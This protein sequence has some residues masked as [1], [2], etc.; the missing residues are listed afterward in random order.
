MYLEIPTIEATEMRRSAQLG[1]KETNSENEAQRVFRAKKS[2]SDDRTSNI[3]T[4]DN[5]TMVEALKYLN[6]CQLAKKSLVSKRFRD[7]IQ[8]HRH[9]LA[10]LYVDTI[11]MSPAVNQ[12]QCFIFDKYFDFYSE[13]YNEWVILN[14]YSKQA[15]L[16]DQ[17]ANTQ[18]SQNI[19]NGYQLYA[20]AHYK[21]PSRREWYDNS[22]VFDVGAE[23]KDDYW[24]AFQHFVRLITDPFIY[25]DSME[26][27]EQCLRP[28]NV[29]DLLT[30]AINKDHNRL[31]CNRLEFCLMGNSHQHI[32]WAKD[33]LRCNQFSMA[34]SIIY[35]ETYLSE[36]AFLDFAMTAGQC[37]SSIIVDCDVTV[38]VISKAMIDFV[39]KFLELENWDDYQG[40][41]SIRS[42]SVPSIDQPPNQAI[43][44]LKN[45]YAKFL[46]KE[47]HND[48]DDSTDYSFEFVNNAIGKKLQ[49]ITK[50]FVVYWSYPL[51]VSM[52]IMNL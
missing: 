5:G 50:I 13:A 12:C 19:P 49:L 23:L 29:L 28:I 2:Q 32:T 21:D 18:S 43:Q 31:H 45:D 48:D 36:K 30:R 11:G 4:M 1:E 44:V 26:L 15:P 47:E 9:S 33:H 6:Y 16:Q 41:Q 46:V 7:L 34:D 38:C 20:Y 25:I 51:P 3:V 35:G 8:T 39:Q 27:T 52:E 17:V 14:G 40:V 37:T 10:L 24:P 42:S 22:T